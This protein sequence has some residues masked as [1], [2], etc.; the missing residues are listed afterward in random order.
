QS[1]RGPAKAQIVIPP[2][3]RLGDVVVEARNLSK[4]FGERLLIDDLSFTV[5]P[6]AIV[7]LIGPNGAGKTTLF[8]MITG[9]EQPDAGTLRLGETVVLGY[10]DQ[11]RESLD[12]NNTVW[13]E[14]S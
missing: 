10:V 14:V 11:T 6:G 2:G 7:G 13:Q 5:P 1:E 12:P 3:P 9:Q 8:R 4:G